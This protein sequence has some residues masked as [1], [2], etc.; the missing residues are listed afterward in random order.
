MRI[1]V[2]NSGSST[3]KFDLLSVD[4]A[5]DGRALAT[6]RVADGLVDRI[7][8]QEA[9]L[10]FNVAS[11][12]SANTPVSGHVDAPRERRAAGVADHRDA[13]AKVFEWLS[14]VPS[15]ERDEHDE[16]NERIRG[17]LRDGID[18]VGHRVVTGADRF[19]A[20]VLIDDAVLSSLEEISDLAPLHNPQVIL[21]MRAARKALGADT[22]MVAVFD[23]AFHATLPDY[24][25][26]YALPW[27]LA[28]RHRIRRYGFHGIA[29]E[30]MLK[31]YSEIASVHAGEA[32]VIT[33]QL[34]NGCS[35]AA[36]RQGRSIDTSMGFTPS[37]GLVM[38][39]RSGDLDPGII[40]YLARK[41]GLDA[42]EIE[43]L[44]NRKAG[45]LGMSGL[46]SDMRDLLLAEGQDRQ[47]KLAIEVFCYR[48]RK[49]IGAYLA[50]LGGAQA[51][52]FGGGIG[53]HA[54]VIRQRICEGME[55]CGL[56]LDHERNVATVG[57]EGRISTDAAAIA[58]YVV[59]V[60]E[61]L[62][63]AQYTAQ[64]VTRHVRKVGTSL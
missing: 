62:L 56:S 34:G 64:Y 13:V 48:A 29:H 22:P 58:A 52:V 9:T 36:I 53:E 54:P 30:Y 2:L 60:Y 39:T 3:L 8:S 11:P 5:A 16:R 50:A 23:T 27:K 15:G 41:E 49:F 28:D 55:W 42:A 24:A 6:R 59:P 31:R 63:I 43:T 38:G 12:P 51:V 37:E 45:L 7:G 25:R 47:A 46:S 40:G 44:L 32:T 17:T 19:S 4:L 35:A 14:T 33:L 21:C 57:V 18:A 1:L 10:Q 20:P 26:T 61:S